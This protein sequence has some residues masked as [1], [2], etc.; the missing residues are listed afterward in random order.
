MQLQ[1]KIVVTVFL[2]L[3]AGDGVKRGSNSKAV[4]VKIAGTY[5]NVHYIEEAGDLL[6]MEIKII[7]LGERY[8][9]A[10]FVCEGSVGPMRV[11]DLRVRGTTIAFDVRESEDAAW[12]FAG[13]VSAKSLKGIVTHSLGGR[14]S[15]TLQRKCGYWD[16]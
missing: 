15:V 13:T 11:V 6:G 2:V 12:S 3:T 8:Q 14:E 1:L 4:P 5:T 7:P 9:A 16:Y 10:V